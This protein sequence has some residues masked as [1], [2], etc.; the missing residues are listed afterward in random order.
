MHSGIVGKV[1]QSGQ[2]MKIDDIKKAGVSGVGGG[3]Q[4][5]SG[6]KN[7][8]AVPVIDSSGK[9]V[10]VID[11]A[12]KIGESCFVARDVELLKEIAEH[13]GMAMSNMTSEQSKMSAIERSRDALTKV[14]DKMKN[15]EKIAVK[16]TEKFGTMLQIT[17]FLMVQREMN[18]I[19]TG[20]MMDGKKL[21]ECDRLSLFLI[22]QEK[23][24]LYT[25]VSKNVPYIRVDFSV[26]IVGYCASHKE[27]L[28]IEDY[29]KDFR[30]NKSGTWETGYTCVSCL[31]VPVI[32]NLGEMLGVI[33]CLNKLNYEDITSPP[34]AF[35]A[36]DVE[37][38]KK[39]AVQ[40]GYA[41]LKVREY[42]KELRENSNLRE[43]VEYLKDKLASADNENHRLMLTHNKQE[44]V[45]SLSKLILTSKSL[46]DVFVSI[47]T[48]SEGIFS[49]ETCFCFFFDKKMGQ[50]YRYGPNNDMIYTDL[51]AEEIQEC[52]EC[53]DV[54]MMNS[55]ANRHKVKVMSKVCN[56]NLNSVIFVN[57]KIENC[58][59]ILVVIGDREEVQF[60]E[61]DWLCIQVLAASVA[62]IASFLRDQG[63][64][65]MRDEQSPSTSQVEHARD[66]AKNNLEY[67]RSRFA[68]KGTNHVAAPAEG[69]AEN[70]YM[71][72][73]DYSTMKQKLKRFRE[74]AY[75]L[76]GLNKLEM[77]QLSVLENVQNHE[78]LS[79]QK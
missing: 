65:N 1:L 18:G 75:Q 69:D 33:Q 15:V 2:A 74:L 53:F 61:S 56:R 3:S 9:L 64:N 72:I 58:I 16:S 77:D 39:F 32:S 47:Q 62:T 5:R 24:D 67:L 37:M 71:I 17:R 26:G 29:H 41:V 4:F 21:L 6:T 20:V 31:C 66:Q 22:D 78:M 30:F 60:E 45:L 50:F 49:C 42:R 73:E 46:N 19:F 28:N 10:G 57:H 70:H 59:E 54:N 12:N 7:L 14:K 34:M 13:V 36:N 55:H 43:T 44:K 51:N 23:Q 79:P 48:Q 35:N 27:V 52:Q 63:T 8:V 76:M 40:I 25:C 11:A 68:Q 38:A